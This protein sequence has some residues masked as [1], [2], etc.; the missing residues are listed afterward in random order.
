M[1]LYSLLGSVSIYAFIQSSRGYR[2]NALALRQAAHDTSVSL[3][4][5]RCDNVRQNLRVAKTE[6]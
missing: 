4:V 2:L 3:T 1:T 5:M 6:N